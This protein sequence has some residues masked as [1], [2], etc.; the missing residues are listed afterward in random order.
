MWRDNLGNKSGSVLVA[1]SGVRRYR[2][3]AEKDY[4]RD[5]TSSCKS[6]TFSI[7]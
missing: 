6:L 7:V 3:K 5:R 2:D 4:L 1:L